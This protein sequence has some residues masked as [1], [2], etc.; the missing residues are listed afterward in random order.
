MQQCVADCLEQVRA[1]V[2]QIHNSAGPGT[3]LVKRNWACTLIAERGNPA[4]SCPC[5]SRMACCFLKT[6]RRG[7]M[8]LF[9][10]GLSPL[11]MHFLQCKIKW[12][13]LDCSETTVMNL[14]IA[15]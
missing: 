1:H 4:A 14:H 12:R 8:V 10:A 7:G 13:T 15:S 2:L 11:S 5:V 3:I 6:Y 9:C